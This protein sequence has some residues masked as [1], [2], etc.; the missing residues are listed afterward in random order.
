MSI[1]FLKLNYKL[2]NFH[3]RSTFLFIF[4]FSTIHLFGQNEAAVDSIANEI[5]I[6]LKNNPEPDDSIRVFQAFGKHLTPF[7]ADMEE[8]TAMEFA[9]NVFFRL[10]KNCK[11]FWDIL[12]RNSPETANWQEVTGI[13]ESKIT[14]EE[15]LDFRK[16]FSFKYLEP[17]GD[18]VH[19]SIEDSQWKERFKDDSY[20]HLNMKWLND[21]TF[22]LTF[23]KSNNE[24]RKNLSKVGDKY[25]YSLI[26]K[27]DNS[28]LICVSIPGG[29]RFSLF[30]LLY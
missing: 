20:S 27:G 28:F 18:S 2:Q 15:F 3:M 23:I 17:N 19:V 6:T 21:S 13:P 9:N 1:L 11:L 5:C 26:E 8:E 12:Q 4:L 25:I 22:E 10:Q 7:V 16:I 30:K 14:P 29:E 24:I